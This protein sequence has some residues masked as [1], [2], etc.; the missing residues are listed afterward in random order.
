MTLAVYFTAQLTCNRRLS[1]RRF[2]GV[3]CLFNNMDEHDKVNN[4]GPIEVS[5][6]NIVKVACQLVRSNLSV[7]E[8]IKIQKSFE[9]T[10]ACT[11]V[12]DVVKN[13]INEI[14]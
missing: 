13:R 10:I 4:V 5:K 3:P 9:N 12:K 14:K 8:K 11:D 1:K 6:D 7:E 2:T